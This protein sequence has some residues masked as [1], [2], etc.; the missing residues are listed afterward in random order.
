MKFYVKDSNIAVDKKSKDTRIVGISDLHYTKS[1]GLYF[2][3]EL[4]LKIMSLSPTHICFLGDL[5]DD[6]SVEVVDWL[7]DLSKIAPVYFAL[8]N[9]DI[10]R[11]IPVKDIVEKT[12][13]TK[14]MMN[15]IKNINNLEV[16]ENGRI[17]HNNGN[18]FMG[19][20]Y[21]DISETEEMLNN[22][23]GYNVDL[24]ND[25]Y[26]IMLSHNPWIMNPEVFKGLKEDYSKIDLILSGHT[27]NGLV[28]H[29]ID[30]VI[31]GNIG[32]YAPSQGVLPK[33]TRGVYEVAGDG[34]AYDGF[35]LPALRTLPEMGG[36]G[37]AI[38]KIVYPPA[39]QLIRVE[40]KK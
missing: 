6:D 18:S 27:H 25:E 4:T 3:S 21:Y 11:Y 7:N 8:G 23:N 33:T 20:P 14:E 1:L 35:I 34:I 39:L 2:L 29:M 10:T 17:V 32:L 37:N 22:A 15:K 19:L 13:L 5:V 9:H 31:P 40:K 16:L 28:P 30:K 26:N 24:S 12:H 38:N 36:A